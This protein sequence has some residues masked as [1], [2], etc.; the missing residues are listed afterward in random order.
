M[1]KVE[2]PESKQQKRCEKMPQR[3]RKEKIRQRDKSN[4]FQF[5][6]AS[7]Q[8]KLFQPQMSHLKK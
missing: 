7:K 2:W 5:A 8:F 3:Q 1:T 6:I 4:K